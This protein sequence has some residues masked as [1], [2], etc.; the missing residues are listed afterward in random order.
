MNPTKL[1]HLAPLQAGF[2]VAVGYWSSLLHQALLLEIKS[3]RMIKLSLDVGVKISTL[4]WWGGRVSFYMKKMETIVRQFDFNP[5]RR[6]I[7]A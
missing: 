5:Y 6:P 3:Y 7:W 1:L 4:W 2:E